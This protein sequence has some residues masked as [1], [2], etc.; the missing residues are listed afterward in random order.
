M[1]E[2]LKLFGTILGKAS[3]LGLVVV[4][5]QEPEKIYT[6]SDGSPILIGFSP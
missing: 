2:A 4:D 1:L 3:Q 6:Y 5:K